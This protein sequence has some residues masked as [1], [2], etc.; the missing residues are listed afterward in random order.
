MKNRKRRR[1]KPGKGAV[2]LN[3]DS[4]LRK[5]DR[6]LRRGKVP[7]ER[8]VIIETAMKKAEARG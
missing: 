4:G 8:M 1:A 7:D 3:W 2:Y 6:A 5:L